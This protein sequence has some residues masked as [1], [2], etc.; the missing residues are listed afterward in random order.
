MHSL[1]RRSQAI[2]TNHARRQRPTW[3]ERA[4]A[5]LA[6]AREVEENS[7]ESV[8]TR[9]SE[10]NVSRRLCYGPRYI[11]PGTQSSTSD[12]KAG[13]HRREQQQ[14]EVPCEVLQSNISLDVSSLQ[15]SS[16]MMEVAESP[17][18]VTQSPFYMLVFTVD[19]LVPIA[20][21]LHWLATEEWDLAA[22]PSSCYPRFVSRVNISRSYA[23]DAG[24]RQQFALPRSD[25]LEPSEEPYRT[26]LSSDWQARNRSVPSAST[27]FAHGSTAGAPDV[28]AYPQSLAANNDA[29]SVRS[30]SGDNGI[31]LNV[32]QQQQQQQSNEIQELSACETYKAPAYG[33]IIELVERQQQHAD[34]ESYSVEPN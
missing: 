30:S 24:C 4:R 12:I 19:A 18:A 15:I 9:P 11:L 29:T 26:L 8:P 34:K 13:S 27:A 31:E 1:F 32:L 33:L 22:T 7:G 6:A 10:V 14:H 20:V 3:E 2:R 28:T 5:A 16:V 17:N 25:W 23:L 21:N